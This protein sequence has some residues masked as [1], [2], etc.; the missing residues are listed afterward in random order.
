M[1]VASRI[2]TNQPR[3][4]RRLRE[5][6]FHITLLSQLGKGVPD[7]L[8]TAY[9]NRTERVE[10]LLVEIK[11]DKGTLTEDERQWHESYP[12][13]GPLLVARSEDDVLHWFG[14]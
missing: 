2:D 14:R 10:A 5:L 4:V 11:T 7:V 13:G 8:V 3:M 9:S 1:R 6:G 12:E